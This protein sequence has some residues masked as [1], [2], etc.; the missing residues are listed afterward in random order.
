MYVLDNMTASGPVDG[1]AGEAGMTDNQI[2]E[3]SI[4]K[5]ITAVADGS[6]T[7]ENSLE[8]EASDEVAKKVGKDPQARA[9]YL[10]SD[11]QKRLHAGVNARAALSTQTISGGG[12]L[13]GQDYLAGDFISFLRN[14]AVMPKLGATVL[15][16]LSKDIVI[17][18][19][20]SA[21]VFQM[22]GYGAA[23]QSFMTFGQVKASPKFG[24][25]TTEYHRSLVIQADPSI[26]F[27]ITNDLF[28]SAVLGMDNYII[29]GLGGESNEP[30][31]W[32]NETGI[33]SVDCAG[34]IDW[35]KIVEMKKK[36]KKANADQLGE[37][38]FLMSPDVEEILMTTPKAGA[39]PVFIM[40][41]D[42][43]LAGC[44][45]EVSNQVSD[46]LIAAG[47]W[48]EV[49]LCDWNLYEVLVNPYGPNSKAGNIE[50]TIFAAFDV[51]TKRAAAIA[52]SKNVPISA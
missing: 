5:A 45:S 35:A 13:V 47:I 50:T 41:D 14:K 32:T 12:A 44:R 43:K 21:T 20:L 46:G 11:L 2:R 19:Q 48:S 15:S 16:G 8:R 52:A 6:W 24:S 18:K 9:F 4:S 30:K 37:I 26:D 7:R 33:A 42:G 27:L 39:Y 25:A 51:V 40:G 31:G 49:V 28:G 10:P 36:L 3:Y 17:P 22:T 38:K 1:G 23:D 34:G 29:N